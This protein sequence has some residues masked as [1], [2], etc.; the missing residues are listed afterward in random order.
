MTKYEKIAEILKVLGH[1]VRLQIVEGIILNECNV[2]KIQK[3][4][5]LAQAT[6]SQHMSLLKRVGVVENKRNGNEVC[7]SVTNDFVKDIVAAI[8]KV[9]EK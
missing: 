2:S 7:Y 1:P 8:K 6:V 9:K 4:M 5:N 3:K